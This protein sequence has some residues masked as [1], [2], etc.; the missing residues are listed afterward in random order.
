MTARDRM[1]E[2]LEAL[3]RHGDV[4]YGEVRFVEETNES[5]RVRDGQLESV[6]AID[7]CGIGIRV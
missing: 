5:L 4:T 1:F 3:K 2:A 7:A 6:D